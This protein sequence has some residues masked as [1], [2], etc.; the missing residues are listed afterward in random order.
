MGFSDREM[1]QLLKVSSEVERS[2]EDRETLVSHYC[3]VTIFFSNN[4]PSLAAG[5]SSLKICF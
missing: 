2:R 3:Y 5:Q 4:L 1:F